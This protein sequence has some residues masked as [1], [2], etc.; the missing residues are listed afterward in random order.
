MKEGARKIN[1]KGLLGKGEGSFAAGAYDFVAMLVC[2]VVISTTLS[3]TG[4]KVERPQSLEKEN[5]YFLRN[6]F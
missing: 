3:L 5:S 1:L 4:E 2:A 6:C